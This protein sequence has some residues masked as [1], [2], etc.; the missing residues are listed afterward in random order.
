[1]RTRTQEPTEKLL[2]KFFLDSLDSKCNNKPMVFSLFLRQN[3]ND[4]LDLTI[5]SNYGIPIDPFENAKKYAF[6]NFVKYILIH[7]K[8]QHGISIDKKDFTDIFELIKYDDSKCRV[9]CYYEL[10]ENYYYI[11]IAVKHYIK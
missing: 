8:N 5:A 6:I 4:E 7:T 1:M 10:E 9:L 3:I 11:I 2:W